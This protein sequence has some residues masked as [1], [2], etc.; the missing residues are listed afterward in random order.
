M[1]FYIKTYVLCDS[2]FRALLI[3]EATVLWITSNIFRVGLEEARLYYMASSGEEEG[4]RGCMYWRRRSL[5][6]NIKVERR[7][8]TQS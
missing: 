4:H 8:T 1:P 2:H 3:L 6:D 5:Q 7:R